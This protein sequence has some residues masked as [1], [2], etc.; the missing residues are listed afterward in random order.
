MSVADDRARRRTGSLD[1]LAD[2]VADGDV[3]GA[4]RRRAV[5]RLRHPRLPR[6][7]PASL[8]RHTPM[9]YQTFTRDPRGRHR[10]WARSFV[11]WRQIAAARPN[12][13]HRAVADLQR[14]G[15]LGGRHHAERRRAAPGRRR[16]GRRRAA[17]RAGPHG[18]P[19]LRRRRRRAPSST[20]GCAR[21]TR[22]FG[23][24]TDEVNP[25]GDAE[26]PDDVL[27]GFVM[28]GCLACGERAAQARRRLLR[29]DRAARPGGPLL[30]AASRGPARLLVL[31]SSLTVMSGYRFVLRAAKL[32]IPVA[33]VNARPDPRR[34]EGRRPRRRPARHRAARAGPPAGVAPADREARAAPRSV[35]MGAMQT[36]LPVADF[37]ES[38]RLLDSPRLGK[39]RVETLQIL[40][41]L[42]LPDYGW[43][44]HPVVTMWRGRTRGAGRPTGWRWSRVWRERGFA[45]STETP[46]RRV[47][48]RGRRP[49]AGGARRGR[50]CCRRGWAT[51]RCTG[52][53][54]PTCWPRTRSSTAAGSPSCSAPSPT[55]CPTSGPVPTTCRRRRR[56][57][58][59]GCGWCG[60][61]PTPSSVPAWP[62]ASSGW[63]R[64]RGSTSTRPG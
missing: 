10:Y 42:E 4:L 26:L 15:L 29:R 6:A 11:G 45:D 30:R 17:R 23:P 28:V 12:D 19:A 56:P 46:D 22:A 8:R 43:A 13:G 14:A 58:A 53:T 2:L 31:G 37:E 64:S 39:Q 50:A 18:L 9:T 47:R 21:P 59:C 60:R 38:A 16:A 52:R 3:A 33:I 34:R 24:R 57:T 25:D 7:P 49:A 41:A 55:T 62:P 36:F 48:P 51:R 35:R 1:A 27:D 44:N 32:G 5:H 40:R 61:A 54:G 63:A 20:S